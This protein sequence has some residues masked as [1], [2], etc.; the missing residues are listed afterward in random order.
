MKIKDILKEF[1]TILLI[2]GG[3]GFFILA[4]L[5]IFGYLF[6][7]VNHSPRELDA[8]NKIIFS[9]DVKQFLESNY[10]DKEYS[11]CLTGRLDFDEGYNFTTYITGYKNYVKGTET[12]VTGESCDGI[13]FIHSHPEP[14][15]CDKYLDLADIESEKFFAKQGVGLFLIQCGK[16]KIET[17]SLRE[18]A[19]DGFLVQI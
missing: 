4:G 13:A 10:N 19:Y 8:E 1:F 15:S 18:P 16:D 5:N 7:D 17:H 14:I 2:L 9:Q 12:G 6:V 3:V 11:A